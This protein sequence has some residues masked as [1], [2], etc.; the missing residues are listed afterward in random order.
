ML[1]HWNTLLNTDCLVVDVGP[2]TV[3][4]IYRVGFTSLVYDTTCFYYNENISKCAD[5]NVLVRDP[6]E[7]FISGV[8]EV[9]R[10]NKLDVFNTWNLIAKDQFIDRHFTPQYL[11][12]MHLYRFYKG[13]VKLRPFSH[14]KKLT[15]IHERK[16]E[17]KISVPLLQKFIDVDYRLLDMVGRTIN[18][19]TLI[20]RLGN[21]LS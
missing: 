1:K 9:C 20:K 18:L 5:I 21:V 19:G 3:Y 11:W 8:N 16:G 17:Q 6:A 15:K 13:N 12:L 7:R 14:I 2:A 4:P 10:Q